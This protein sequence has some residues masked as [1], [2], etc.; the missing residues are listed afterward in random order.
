MKIHTPPEQLGFSRSRLARVK[1]WMQGYIDAGKLPGAATLVA[2][3]GKIAF[4]E[5][6]GYGDL[7]KKKP[8]A[9][10]SILRFYSMSKP[11]TAVAVMM[12]YEQ[13]L[14]QGRPAVDIYSRI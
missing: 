7:E 5:V 14:F 9:Q 6:M 8:L 12:L 3:H 2:R 10:D 11:I 13:G 4:C 1:S